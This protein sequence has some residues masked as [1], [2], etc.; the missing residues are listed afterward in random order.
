MDI[1]TDKL[2]K[3][4][5][6]KDIRET[7]DH[8]FFKVGKRPQEIYKKFPLVVVVETTNICNQKCIA[9]P[10]KNLTRP[11]QLMDHKL[12]KSIVDE[13]AKYDV[14]AWFHFMGEPLTNPHIFELLDYASSSEIKYFGMSSNATLLN[15]DIIEN[16]L[17]SGMHRFEMS[18]DSLDPKLQGQLRPGTCDPAK[19]IKNVHEFFRI[20]YKRRQKYPITSVAIRE[21]KENTHDLEEF[22][23][24]WNKILQKPDFI[25]SIRYDSWGGHESR[26]H[27]IYQIPAKRLPCMKLWN[28][29]IILSDGRLVTCNA[30]FDAQV[31]M[32]D[33]NS[34]SIREIWF[35]E[36][37]FQRRQKHVDGRY[38]EVSI[39]AKCDDW[40]REI[41]DVSHY[42]NWTYQHRKARGHVKEVS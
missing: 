6:A 23:D 13:I 31:V 42:R 2:M 38:G 15:T 9:C 41:Q 26:D 25:M 24:H 36:H 1:Q 3:A 17:D 37:Y 27:D 4:L 28:T 32:G 21:L 12:F 40:C 20:K 7:E 29:A 18:V 8:I 39:C 5:R 14:R 16:I 34:S 22:A 33:T 11:R 35:G 19:T 30:M 10:Q